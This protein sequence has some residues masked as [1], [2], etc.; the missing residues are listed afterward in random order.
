MI[1]FHLA[2]HGTD[3]RS[4]CGES[5]KGAEAAARRTF[6]IELVECMHCLQIAAAH[7]A[8]A[9]TRLNEMTVLKVQP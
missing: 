6:Q 7:G 3:K 4:T 5:A 2:I 1:K 9:Q 8:Q